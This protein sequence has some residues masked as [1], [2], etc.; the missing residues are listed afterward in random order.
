MAHTAGP[1]RVGRE[2]RASPSA[3][4]RRVPVI[5]LALVGCAIAAYLS[6]YQLHVIAGIWDPIFG[7]GSERVLTSFVAN[8]LPV[9]D[10]ALGAGAY[11]LEA[12]AGVVGGRE[13]WCTAPWVVV[14]Y[15]LLVAALGLTSVGLVIAQPLLFRTGCTLCLASAAC[16]FVNAWLARA[17]VWA[18]LAH[19][20]REREHGRSVWRAFWGAA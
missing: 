9:P 2:E 16:S 7:R 5:V 17:E 19:L 18:T 11:L 1:S 14:G 8:T 20:R 10:A 13:R 4:Q 3:W 12:V 6:L 15:G